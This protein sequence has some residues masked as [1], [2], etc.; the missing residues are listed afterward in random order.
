MGEI[1]K[2]EKNGVTVYPATTT[3]AVVDPFF[4]ASSSDSTMVYNVSTLFPTSGKNGTNKYDL[5]TAIAL[6]LTM[7]ISRKKE[8]VI[9]CFLNESGILEWYRSKDEYFTQKGKWER[10]LLDVYN[11]T[12]EKPLPEG[13]YYQCTDANGANFAPSFI[14]T[15]VRHLGF[16]LFIRTAE[17]Q[18][19]LFKYVSINTIGGWGA[20]SRWIKIADITDIKNSIGFYTAGLATVTSSNNITCDI[21]DFALVKGKSFGLY[22][23]K[24]FYLGN[25]QMN[26]SNTGLKDIAKANGES[27]SL[28][29]IRHV[30]KI[31]QFVYDGEK[32]ILCNPDRTIDIDMSNKFEYSLSE[33]NM[34]EIGYIS[35]PG[36]GDADMTSRIRTKAGILFKT[37]ISININDGY[38]LNTIVKINPETNETTMEVPGNISGVHRI[39]EDGLLY[40]FFFRK[41]NN[42][43]FNDVENVA[44]ISPLNIN[45][46]TEGDERLDLTTVETL[47]FIGTS[48]TEGNGSLRDKAMVSYMSAL[49]DWNVM[50]LGISGCDYVECYHYLLNNTKLTGSRWSEVL[51]GGVCLDFL[52]GN[53]ENIYFQEPMDAKYSV[54]NV[55]RLYSL[56]QSK[57]FEVIPGS[58]W[59]D[60]PNSFASVQ[61]K[62]A[63]ELGLEVININNECYRI[64]AQSFTPYWYSAHFASR[65]VANQFYTLNQAYRIRRARTAIKIFRN[66]I[67]VSDNSKLL[68]NDLFERIKYWRELSV[69]HRAIADGSEKYVDRLDLFVQLDPRPFSMAPIEYTQL[70][71][72]GNIQFSDKALI[73]FI[74]PSTAQGIKNFRFSLTNTSSPQVYVRKYQDTSLDIPI[75]P[76]YAVFRIPGGVSDI[77]T[78][79]IF[80]DTLNEGIHFTVVRTIPET[81]QILCNAD[82]TFANPGAT[83]D[84][85]TRTSDSKTYAADHLT[86]G[87]PEGYIDRAYE[88]IGKWELLDKNED[89]LYYINDIQ[90][91][92]NYDKVSVLVD[93]SGTM[94]SISDVYA[95]YSKPEFEKNKEKVL[96]PIPC[97]DLSTVLLED[98]FG[99]SKGVLSD[100][101]GSYIWDGNEEFTTNTGVQDTRNHISSYYK[102]KGATKILHLKKGDKVTYTIPDF[103]HVRDD[104]PQLMRLKI[105][106]RYFPASNLDINVSTFTITPESFDFAKLGIKYSIG[107]NSIFT[108][109]EY[110]PASFIELHKD[111]Y[112]DMNSTGNT[113][114]IIAIDDDIELLYVELTK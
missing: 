85:L 34:L 53:A 19:D 30:D 11:L 10:I 41:D 93:N 12:N 83:T 74:L 16:L 112:F 7:N 107:T 91:Y 108:D 62:V 8:G 102:A 22:F 26:I 70:R 36:G 47:L 31:Y 3:D 98:T 106:C 29:D 52:G 94:F 64:N 78:G 23:N 5:D 42:S 67:S 13:Q 60:Q 101:N 43:D 49:N 73:E 82:G 57:G 72:K 32:Y 99:E 76:A 9:L 58:Y 51:T 37:P 109:E 39:Y 2:I 48:H 1:H 68:Y 61:L 4:K 44:S 84:T 81:N 103:S 89:G 65:T 54:Q 71:N 18:W 79:D 86:S 114:E 95:L 56:I 17:F 97:G 104:E 15:N 59:G 46:S 90:P 21:D 69:G 27:F 35:N 96:T 28:T 80:T 50:N 110:I 6:F 20:P 92:M 38:Y 100:D 111:I 55:K 33:E 77:S 14:D 25:P 40:R 105:V 113:L 24:A 66:R 45:L 88:P 75:T 63:K 87:V